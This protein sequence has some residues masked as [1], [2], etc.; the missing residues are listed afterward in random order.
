MSDDLVVRPSSLTTFASCPRRWAARHIAPEVTTAGYTLR[1]REPSHVG[2]LVGTGVHA[3][4]SHS[5]AEKQR[6]GTLGTDADAEEQ[7]ILAFRQRAEEDGAS[8]DGTTPDPNTAEKQIRRMSRV[9]RDSPAAEGTPIAVEERLEAEIRPGLIIS[10]Q[11]DATM[12]GSPDDVIRDTKTGTTRRANGAQYGAYGLLWRAHGHQPGSLIEDFLRR[13]R[14]D[15][16][17]PPVEPHIIPLQTATLEAWELIDA[18]GNAVSEFR[19]R[20]ADPNGRPPNM[21]FRANPA[22]SLCAARWCPAWGTDFCKA[23][24]T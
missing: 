15:R 2:G 18:L 1:G 13:T 19:R 14:L 23:H 9:W 8:W 3:A 10:G 7:G 17:Q 21:A 22:D 16:E 12:V 24:A 4:A 20:V 11:M 5:L 6:T